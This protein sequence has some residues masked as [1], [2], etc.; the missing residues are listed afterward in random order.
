MVSLAS[1]WLPILLSAVAVFIV[2]AI[3]HMA[4]PYHK[5]DFQQLPSE[6][7]I[8]NAL[9]PHNIP[10]GE[11]MFPRPA[12]MAAMKDPA[13]IEKHKRGPVGILTVLRSGE[14]GM[15]RQLTQW[16][17]YSLVISLFS[18]Y[19]ASHALP[20]GA[21]G[22]EIFRYVTTLGFLGYGLGLVHDS[23]WFGRKWSSTVKNLIDGFIYGAV[24]A[25]VFM[26]LWPQPGA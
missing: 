6:D 20:A 4:L 7:A 23:I 15:G 25:L 14:M 21:R 9:A 13:Y 2:S 12:S 17:I 22:A 24:S 18:A 10:V 19:I 1:L 16:F 11:Y 26:W 8:L 3:I 5:S